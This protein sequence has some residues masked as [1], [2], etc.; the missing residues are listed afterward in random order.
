MIKIFS[1]DKQ[2]LNSDLDTYI[3]KFKTYKRD[4]SIKYPEVKEVYK[5]FTD[6]E[7]AN[8]YA[9]RLKEAM[10]ML[11]ITALPEPIVYKEEKN[12]L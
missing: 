6:K 4:F 11:G 10:K 5:A 3:V 8:E 9:N 12:S 7:E 1:K 2:I